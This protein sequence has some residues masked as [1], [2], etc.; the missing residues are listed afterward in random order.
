MYFVFCYVKYKFYSITTLSALVSTVDQTIQKIQ[1]FRFS[2]L[3]M[4]FNIQTFQIFLSCS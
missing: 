3:E 4:G 2:R 1:I